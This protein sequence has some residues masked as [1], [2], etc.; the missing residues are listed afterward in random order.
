MIIFV[1]HSKGLY[2]ASACNEIHTVERLRIIIPYL[3]NYSA[4][5]E[6]KVLEN[7]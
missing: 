4:A 2:F 5:S 3:R 6:C 7:M 1:G